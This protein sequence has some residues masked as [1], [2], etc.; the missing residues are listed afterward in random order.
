MPKAFREKQF[1]VCASL[2]ALAQCNFP[3]C[4]FY[5]N[6][7]HTTKIGQYSLYLKN[8]CLARGFISYQAI[9]IK[10]QENKYPDNIQQLRA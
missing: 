3:L 9:S 2:S 6:V 4:P 7:V 5:F 8:V 10:N 1:S